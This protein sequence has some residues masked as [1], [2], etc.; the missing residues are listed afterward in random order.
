MNKNNKNTIKKRKI[1]KKK[2]SGG[3]RIGKGG[4][5]WR[6]KVSNSM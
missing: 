5:G 2:Q 4:F 3:L 1:S 6:Y